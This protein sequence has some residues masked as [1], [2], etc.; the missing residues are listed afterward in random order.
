MSDAVGRLRALRLLDEPV[1]HGVEGFQQFF[2][3]WTEPHDDWQAEVEEVG[4]VDDERVVAMM[5]QRGRINGTDSWVELRSALL[6]TIRDHR[7]ERVQL[8]DTF[9]AALESTRSTG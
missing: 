2:A 3:K 1:Y 5:R 7:F 4:A 6:Y 9:E 8:F